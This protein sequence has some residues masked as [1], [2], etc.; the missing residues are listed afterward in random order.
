MGTGSFNF[1]LFKNGS[2]QENP[3]FRIL[4]RTEQPS[5]ILG[6]QRKT[7]GRTSAVLQPPM[8]SATASRHAKRYR[9]IIILDWPTTADESRRSCPFG[10]Q[11][12]IEVETNPGDQPVTAITQGKSVGRD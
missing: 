12:R 9:R 7:E 4:W 11:L 3:E 2:P 8:K 10:W 5:L 1:F 6:H